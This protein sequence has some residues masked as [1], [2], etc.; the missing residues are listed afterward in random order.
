MLLCFFESCLGFWQL[1]SHQV[2]RNTGK[3]CLF[4]SMIP[5]CFS[6]LYFFTLR[7]SKL[8]CCCD[9]YLIS[10]LVSRRFDF[11]IANLSNVWL[12]KENFIIIKICTVPS[13][14]CSRADYTT[15]PRW[16]AWTRARTNMPSFKS[17][18]ATLAVLENSWRI[19]TA[20]SP[21]A[22]SPTVTARREQQLPASPSTY[23]WFQK[24]EKL[25][26]I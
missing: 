7:E 11:K 22:V 19:E 14:L 15:Y 20:F 13:A 17:K 21:R 4:L 6:T 9:F 10:R 1:T 12:Y 3:V 8:F 16:L 23:K 18:M 25:K 24:C 2:S 26:L 5:L